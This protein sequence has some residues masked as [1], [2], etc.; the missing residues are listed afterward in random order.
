LITA[1]WRRITRVLNICCL[2]IALHSTVAACGEE[3]TPSSF[4][5]FLE[6][7]DFR[8]RLEGG[9]LYQD[10]ES[11]EKTG[12]DM[13]DY[14]RRR[15]IYSNLAQRNPELRKDRLTDNPLLHGAA[16]NEIILNA[17]RAGFGLDGRVLMEDRGMSYGVYNTHN[18]TVFSR[19]RVFADSSF[20]I[21]GEEIDFGI[22]SG[23]FDNITLGKGLTLYNIDTQGNRFYIGWKN[24]RL[25][26]DTVADM[27]MTY[28]LN[29]GDVYNYHIS[30]EEIDLFRGFSLGLQAGE[31][32]YVSGPPEMESVQKQISIAFEVKRGN[33]FRLYSETGLRKHAGTYFDRIDQSANVVGADFNFDNSFI[34]L[35]IKAERRYY[36]R[37]F[38][39]GFRSPDQTFNFRD[40]DLNVYNNTVGTHLYPISNF[41]RPFSQWAVYTEYQNRDVSSYIL[42]ADC[43]YNLPAGF[44]LDALL[45][46]NYMD[47]SSEDN[48]LYPFYSLAAG[49]KPL[50]GTAVSVGLTNRA[51]NLD[52]QYPTLYLLESPVI[53]MGWYYRI[54]F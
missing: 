43:R 13:P 26:Y 2:L 18:A 11:W 25:G 36:G 6:S 3:V 1:H 17:S 33:V 22:Y 47:V 20:S 16:F 39:E 40:N 9:I 30:L 12:I 52:E 24:L 54:G 5:G 14:I 42:Q 4:K 35:D 8:L 49:W 51:M 46:L 53:E 44:F 7:F 27:E 28:S 10:I 48:F 19:F 37:Y 23:H 15:K 50:E 41:L 29:I 32:D 45:D 21:L 34:T 31:Y 38:N